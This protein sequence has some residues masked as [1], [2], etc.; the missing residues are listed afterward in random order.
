MTCAWKNVCSCN[1]ILCILASCLGLHGSVW[2]FCDTGLGLTCG[3][4]HLLCDAK[5]VLDEAIDGWSKLGSHCSASSGKSACEPQPAIPTHQ[6]GMSWVFHAQPVS[7]WHLG[8]PWLLPRA[9]S[10]SLQRCW[11][12]GS[13]GG[14]Y[15]PGIDANQCGF[16]HGF[17]PPGAM[18]WPPILSVAIPIPVQSP[19]GWAGAALTPTCFRCAN[20]CRQRE[21]LWSEHPDLLMNETRNRDVGEGWGWSRW[22]QVLD[23]QWCLLCGGDLD[24]EQLWPC[25]LVLEK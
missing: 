17:T 20:D 9:G 5:A 15:P 11:C 8:Q 22:V 7:A 3:L 2:F 1:S 21:V 25:D 24:L 16:S 13:D 10:S 14:L 23:H 18:L 4:G 6:P 12:W 19:A